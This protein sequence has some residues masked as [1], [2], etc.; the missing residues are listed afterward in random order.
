MKI[1][2][3]K[4]REVMKKQELQEMESEYR[5]YLQLCLHEVKLAGYLLEEL[6]DFEGAKVVPHQLRRA[7]PAPLSSPGRGVCSPMPPGWRSIEPDRPAG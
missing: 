7:L 1:E 4:R 5:M 2:K 3:E 6:C